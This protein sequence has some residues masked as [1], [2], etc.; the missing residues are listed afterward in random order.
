MARTYD[1]VHDPDLRAALGNIAVGLWL[2]LGQPM[3]PAVTKDRAVA[4]ALRVVAD[5]IADPG[6]QQKT[7]AL[8]LAFDEM[9]PRIWVDYRDLC[10]A[11]GPT[12]RPG[13]SYAELMAAYMAAQA[14]LV[15]WKINDQ[16]S[17]IGRRIDPRS[18]GEAVLHQFGM[19]FEEIAALTDP[20]SGGA[21][22]AR[23]RVVRHIK[24]S[25]GT[26][27]VA[28]LYSAG[29]EPSAVPVEVRPVVFRDGMSQS[30]SPT[31]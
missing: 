25:G 31:E 1:E 9:W 21:Q 14:V 23:Q 19:T 13:A 29:V 15:A 4:Q 10:A 5:L 11:V 27:A 3:S 16:E 30:E 18:G 8:A 26:P 20:I 24:H 7:F 17:K 28:V 12:L 22:R 6:T 2:S